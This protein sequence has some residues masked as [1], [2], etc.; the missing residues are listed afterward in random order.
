MSRKRFRA[1]PIRSIIH[2]FWFLTSAPNSSRSNES[3]SVDNSTMDIAYIPREFV[4]RLSPRNR[5]IC[6][7]ASSCCSFTLRAI[8]WQDEP[9]R[10]DVKKEWSPLR[11]PS[12]PGLFNL[13]EGARR[14]TPTTEIFF[15]RGKDKKPRMDGRVVEKWQRNIGTCGSDVTSKIKEISLTLRW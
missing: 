2:H 9:G 15:L 7:L 8:H 10:N 12:L 5:R 14:I 13:S 3:T 6:N 1:P 4:L 11:F